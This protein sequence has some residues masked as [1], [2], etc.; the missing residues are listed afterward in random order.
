VERADVEEQ[1]P[2]ELDDARP[3]V[4]ASAA[5]AASWSRAADVKKTE[6]AKKT[7]A[8]T[9]EPTSS[10]KPG[11]GPTRKHAEP[12]AKS[13]PIQHVA[14]SVAPVAGAVS[15][16]A[17]TR[18]RSTLSTAATSPDPHEQA[19]WWAHAGEGLLPPCLRGRRE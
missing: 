18:P 15:G 9:S 11:N 17:L 6:P 12:I 14:V 16:A 7:A 3:A 8:S 19:G 4:Q 10:T 1:R 13:T 2:G 5:V